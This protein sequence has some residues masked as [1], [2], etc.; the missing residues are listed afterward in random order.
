MAKRT[1]PIDIRALLDAILTKL[2][3]TKGP[4]SKG[5][6]TAWCPFHKDGQGKA[7]HQPNLSVF[8]R[9]FYCHA[10]HEKGPL[11]KLAEALG[12]ECSRPD[13]IEQTYDYR[14][15]A[16]D[17]LYQVVRTAGKGFFQ[18]RPNGKGGW[19][20]GL[21]KVNPVLYQLPELLANP[22][23]TKFIVEGEKDA[24]RLASLGLLA[25]TNSSGA[26]KWRREF[27]GTFRGQRV[28][29]L[30]D[31]DQAGRD[32]AND[33]ASSLVG[34]AASIK[35]LDLPDL[36][37]KGDVSDWLNAGGTREMLLQLADEAPEYVAAPKSETAP[38]DPGGSDDDDDTSA[39]STLARKLVAFV[40][41]DGTELFHDER[42]EPFAR[43]PA[44]DGG[45]VI[46]STH[47]K[48]FQR[49]LSL[50]GFERLNRALGGEVLST[51]TR[52]LD[53]IACFQRAQHHLYVRV[54]WHEDDIWIDLDGRRAIRVRPGD[55]FIVDDPPILFRAFPH[56]SPMPEP[57]RGG[58]PRRVFEFLN[59]P[60]EERRLLYLGY[61]VASLVPD[62]PIPVLVTHG[63]QGA[64][65]TTL[66]KVTKRLLDPSRVEVRGGVKDLTEYAQAAAQ[67]RML[68]FDNL[69]SI[70]DWLSDAMCR[71]VTGDG[72]SKRALYSDEDNTIFEIRAVV[73][74]S[75]INNVATRADLLD[76][77][78]IMELEAISPEKRREERAFWKEFGAAR[79]EIFGGLLDVL[80]GAMVIHPGLHL[81]SIPRM[82]DAAKW[83]AA[84]AQALGMNPDDFLEAYAGNV[85]R[86]TEAAFEGSLVAQTMLHFMADQEEWNGTASELLAGLR[87]SAEAQQI[88]LRC[89]EWPKAANALSRRLNESRPALEAQGIRF[90]R[91]GGPSRRI[92]VRR[93]AGNTVSTVNTVADAS[94][95]DERRNGNDDVDDDTC[96]RAKNIVIPMEPWE[97]R[98]PASYDVDDPDDIPGHFFPNQRFV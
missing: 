4:D 89:R 71:T 35:F 77:S 78:V 43:I 49:A 63:A 90:S 70:P 26:G 27:A 7:P 13:S 16:D 79:G 62:I 19:I 1:S 93:V 84:A 55:W 81:G 52:T 42:Q 85:K 96:G 47:A 97:R 45:H 20:N 10:C 95:A 92:E 60:D 6:Y 56:Q 8:E 88:D 21:G 72:F 91:T 36:P 51:A 29:V 30:I 38:D 66:L 73:G 32:H 76:R 68:V 83:G 23:E 58:D 39:K 59:L 48:S 57:V 14:S 22:D 53:A 33:V 80:A 31:N 87:N 25:T 54:A 94:G 61:L 98:K 40:L 12:I 34:I 44:G 69:T 75:G 2:G 74:I 46:V 28:V 24:D 3:E 82:A 9:G 64:T 65:K 67:N 17:V 41:G 86:Q 18:R 11:R 5:A 50:I 37:L 15:A